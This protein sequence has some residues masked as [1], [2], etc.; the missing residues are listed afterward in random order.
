VARGGGNRPSDLQKPL[1]D[2]D[3]D[4]RFS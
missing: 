2:G 4:G 1:T 3:L